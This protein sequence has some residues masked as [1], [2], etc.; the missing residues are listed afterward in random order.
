MA[1]IEAG[2]TLSAVKGLIVDATTVD[3]F[4][5]RSALNFKGEGTSVQL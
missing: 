1:G 5:H 2:M 4:L 3:R